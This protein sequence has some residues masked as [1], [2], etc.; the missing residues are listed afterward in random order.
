VHRYNEL[1]FADPRL[2]STILPIGD[3]M[4]LS[5]KLRD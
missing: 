2:Q 1:I 4:T 3:G 5:V